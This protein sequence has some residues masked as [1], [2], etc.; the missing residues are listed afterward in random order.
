MNKQHSLK[1]VPKI[2]TTT[3][4]RHHKFV[5]VSVYPFPYP[6]RTKPEGR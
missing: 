4:A 1:P 2:A 5:Y 3:K 6:R